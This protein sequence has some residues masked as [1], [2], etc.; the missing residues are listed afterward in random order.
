MGRTS[1]A[2]AGVACSS[3]PSGSLL[4]IAVDLLGGSV[5]PVEGATVEGRRVSGLA[6]E[7][8]RWKEVR[9]GRAGGRSVGTARRGLRASAVVRFGR[10]VHRVP[11]G[12]SFIL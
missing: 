12:R 8:G 5:V 7:A 6:A 1:R 3:V 11:R 10:S 4:G 9:P 2:V